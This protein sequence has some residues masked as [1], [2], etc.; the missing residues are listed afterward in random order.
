[1]QMFPLIIIQN[2][3]KHLPLL[4]S[5]VIDSMAIVP[6]LVSTLLEDSIPEGIVPP[7][8]LVLALSGQALRDDS[9]GCFPA[10]ES[11]HFEIGQLPLFLSYQF[12]TFCTN[13]DA[14]K[15]Y[16]SNQPQMKFTAMG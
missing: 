7:H 10:V 11:G 1:M 13:S 4:A 8:W 12:P 15:E 9:F 16:W 6:V 3:F 5:Y 2:G 14:C